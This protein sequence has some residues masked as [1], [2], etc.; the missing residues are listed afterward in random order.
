MSEIIPLGVARER[1][2]KDY[3]AGRP[4]D[5]C[6]AAWWRVYR[7]VYAEMEAGEVV[8]AARKVETLA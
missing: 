3:L 2:M 4:I 1:A 5:D 8:A 7:E 6:P